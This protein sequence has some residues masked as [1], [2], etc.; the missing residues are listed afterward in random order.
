MADRYKVRIEVVSQQGRCTQEHKVGDSWV[1]D[2]K[3]P[4]GICLFAFNALLPRLQ[5]LEFGGT[6]PW[7][8][9]PDV[10]RAA[11]PDGNNPVVFELRRLRD[12]P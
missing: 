7:A 9:D 4:E 8:K 10:V 2:K 6:F 12:Q 5:V 1:V 11:C 3:T